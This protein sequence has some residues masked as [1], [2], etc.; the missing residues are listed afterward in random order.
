MQDNRNIEELSD[1]AWG[2]MKV[3]L[4]REM[5]ISGE[6]KRPPL[7]WWFWGIAAL[8]LIGML[9]VI[10][11][12]Q[13]GTPEWK[14]NPLETTPAL[15]QAVARPESSDLATSEIMEEDPLEEISTLRE[16][17]ASDLNAVTPA[18]TTINQKAGNTEQDEITQENADLDRQAFNAKTKEK[19]GSTGID[20]SIHQLGNEEPV[21]ESETE[22]VN[23]S[24]AVVPTA[25]KEE[26]AKLALL[27]LKS[28]SNPSIE[29]LE[30]APLPLLNRNLYTIKKTLLTPFEINAGL[31]GSFQGGMVSGLL[32][33]ARSGLKLHRRG[34]WSFQTGVGIHYQEE[35]FSVDFQPSGS[36]DEAAVN[37]SQDQQN[38]PSTQDP[39]S[40]SIPQAVASS[41][42]RLQSTYFDV[43]LLVDWRFAPRWSLAAGSRLSWLLSTQWKSPNNALE[44]QFGGT[45]ASFAFNLNNAG[46]QFS[47]YQTDNNN[48]TPTTFLLK[49]FYASG[50]LGLTFRPHS[51]WHLRLQYQHSMTNL[52]DHDVFQTT[53]RSL[54]LSAGLRF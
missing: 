6:S 42:V 40:V 50:T 16:A 19:V 41:A 20:E 2:K 5:P 35:P 14:G 24:T 51:Q 11:F 48:S 12:Q 38:D 28:L 43:P 34:K 33:D 46:R 3:L 8:V 49:D 37:S 1:Q 52:L 26:S 54:W 21:A 32:A 18:S 45:N 44:A 36:N 7:I 4:D 9:S 22:S 25:G 53:D 30:Q 23:P 27:E 13:S 15:D 39:E 10:L 17:K 31:V 29:A 47:I